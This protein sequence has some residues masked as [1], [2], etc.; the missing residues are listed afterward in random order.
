MDQPHHTILLIEDDLEIQEVMGEM[1]KAEGYGFHATATGEDGLELAKSLNPDLIIL[2][3][4][5]LPGLDGW[6]VCQR[7]KADPA[8]AK[9]PIIF[10]TARAAPIHKMVGMGIFKAE[11]Y[12]VKPI[13]W[14]ELTSRVRRVL[15]Q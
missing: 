1:L 15:R 11:E 12:L 2:D 9:I 6:E 5:L 8:T 4:I 14:D 10:L 7:L 3:I 13:P